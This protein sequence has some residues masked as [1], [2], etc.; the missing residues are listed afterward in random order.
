[1]GDKKSS[2]YNGVSFD[3]M[4]EQKFDTFNKNSNFNFDVDP[5]K[6]QINMQ[7]VFQSFKDLKFE[8]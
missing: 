4:S 2:M 8:E 7:Q 6:S 1:M 5:S 3:G